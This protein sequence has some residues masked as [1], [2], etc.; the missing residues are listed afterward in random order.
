MPRK[1]PSF[2][3][4]L[5]WPQA[6]FE[7][8]DIVCHWCSVDLS[9]YYSKR[10]FLRSLLLHGAASSELWYGGASFLFE[11]LFCYGRLSCSVW[12]TCV[13]PRV[14]HT[15]HCVYACKFAY[16]ILMLC[17]HVCTWTRNIHIMLIILCVRV[18][19]CL[20]CV[21]TFVCDH[22]VCL[23]LCMLHVLVL[24]VMIVLEF[25][26]CLRLCSYLYSCEWL[27]SSH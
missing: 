7:F 26:L 5:A 2:G 1:S 21:C 12:R 14:T 24:A 3:G 9:V 11:V 22:L 20:M 27:S 10:K 19:V 17:I 25:C 18:C 16:V 6:V 15:W 13:D 4:S 8:G 23:F